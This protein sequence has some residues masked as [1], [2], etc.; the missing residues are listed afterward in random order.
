MHSSIIFCK[1]STTQQLKKNW[2]QLLQSIFFCA[3][4]LCQSRQI[5]IFEIAIFRK[6]VL[7]G[8]QKLAGFLKFSCFP[9]WP[10]AKL[11]LIPLME[12]HHCGYMINWGDKKTH[13]HFG[14]VAN[15]KASL[16]ERNHKWLPW[17]SFG[18]KYI[19]FLEMLNFFK[20]IFLKKEKNCVKGS[21]A[22]FLNIQEYIY[23]SK[24]N[25]HN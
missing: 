7:G 21:E 12:D 4:N 1:I 10:V 8:G 18:T 13:M 24:W 11:W 9:L 15:Y 25:L 2:V 5:N 17:H 14:W 16:G 20:I 19:L 3:K 22:S 23:I 6:W